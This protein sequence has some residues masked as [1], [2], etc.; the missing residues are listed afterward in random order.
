MVA[1]LVFV[2][3]AVS[4]G[5]DGYI[6]RH[7]NQRTELGLRLDPLA[8]KL[9]LTSGLVFLAANRAFDP[10]I[11]QWFPVLVLIRESVII[12][13]AI[14]ITQKRGRVE[15]RPSFIGKIST[16]LMMGILTGGLLNFPYTVHLIYIT[17][18]CAGL[19]L[20][21]YVRNGFVQAERM[22]QRK[23]HG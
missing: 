9:L 12:F 2:L 11:P 22:K 8:D 21:T 18:F 3:A 20:A 5:V 10:G 19:S 16:V 13:G 23:N 1:L 6:A 7:W 4:D 17:L 14:L 15:V